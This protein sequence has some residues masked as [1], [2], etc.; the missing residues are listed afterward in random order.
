ME[1]DP[2][3]PPVPVPE[4][5][6]AQPKLSVQFERIGDGVRIVNAKRH[7]AIAAFLML[8]LSIWTMGCIML[9]GAVIAQFSF[10]TLLFA[11]PF[12]AAEVFVLAILGTLIASREDFTLDEAGVSYLYRVYGLRIQNRQVPLAEITSFA[13]KW[14][15]PKD[16]E[17]NSRSL[18]THAVLMKTIGA[19]LKFAA[20]VTKEERDWLA[21]TLNECLA[22][23]KRYSGPITRVEEEAEVSPSL[24]SELPDVLELRPPSAAQVSAPSDTTWVQHYDFDAFTFVQRGQLTL[25]GLGFM[26]FV[27]LFWNG[28]VGVFVGLL[29]GF[30]P[31]GRKDA[32]QGFEWW[33]L[34][35]FLIPFELIGLM[36]IGGLIA[37]LLEPVRRSR[38]ILY[39]NAIAY[40]VAWLGIGRTWRY[41]ITELDCLELRKQPTKKANDAQNNG[42][43]PASSDATKTREGLLDE[44]DEEETEDESNGD[45]M[46]PRTGNQ[47]H[48][49]FMDTQRRE[50][51]RIEYLTLGEACWMADVVLR[52]RSGWFVTARSQ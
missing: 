43:K 26:L 4:E 25:A 27:C 49:A 46:A 48:L 30:T 2:Y 47:Y 12:W 52:E 39:R 13:R 35:L 19:P 42:G 16:D 22:S 37:M 8:W 9:V 21:L 41:E 1:T 40:R 5:A 20:G 3:L 18:G 50:V 45:L 36:I 10:F 44:L 7:W 23:L 6:N 32:V 31:D 33:F 17:N 24:S 34:F 28:I 29:F 11:L 14:E 51:C 38:W 15:P